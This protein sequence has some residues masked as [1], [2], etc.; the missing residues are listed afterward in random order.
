MH[1]HLQLTIQHCIFDLTCDVTNDPEF[2]N[3]YV[4]LIFFGDRST[5]VPTAF[6]RFSN[7]TEE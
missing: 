3:I 4:P 2:N 7:S 6:Y 1:L 5:P